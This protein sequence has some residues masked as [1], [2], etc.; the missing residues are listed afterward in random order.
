MSGDK[1]SI[2]ISKDL[3]EKAKK[4]IEENGGFKSVEELVEFLLEEAIAAETGEG[5]AI[6]PEDEEK[7]KERL[8]SLGY[9]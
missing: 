9:L 7:V 1:V 6:S 2:E 5:V 4:F 8:R 3:Y